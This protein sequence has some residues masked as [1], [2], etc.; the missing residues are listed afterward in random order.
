MSSMT[1]G[2][3]L[4]RLDHSSAGDVLGSSGKPVTSNS[5]QTSLAKDESVLVT[6][7]KAGSYAAFEELVNRYEKK[8][9]RLGLNLTGNPEDAEDLLQETF[10]KAF[11]HL[12]T[13]REDSRF[14]TWIVRIAINEGLMK[15]RKR[16]SSKEVQVEDPSNS[17]G[18]FVPRE[19]ADWRPNPEQA[20]ERVEMETIL[21]NAAK[22]LPVTFRTVF[23]LRDVEGLSTEETA[24]M[25][26]LSVGA[27]K[28]R[29]FRARLR[30]REE[31]SKI[32]KR[33]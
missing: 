6:E 8:I 27:V 11:Q 29:L 17:D 1:I 31:L 32:F 25:L 21:R 13:F 15:L 30:L 3:S 26:N 2:R 24:E 20:M 22:A 23:F 18:E 28:A 9:Y 33:G 10:L 12:P 14:Y 16:R 5:S 4:L 19:F 7:A